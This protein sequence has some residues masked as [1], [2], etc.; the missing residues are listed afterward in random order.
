MRFFLLSLFTLSASARFLYD[1]VDLKG[2]DAYDFVI[3]GG[4]PGGSTVAD[5][6]SED[7][8]V[9]VLLLEA[10]GENDPTVDPALAIPLFCTTLTPNTAYD[11]NYTTIPQEELNGRSIPYPL[12]IGLGGS[13][14]VNCLVY[15]RGSADDI[16]TWA[17]LSGDEGWSWDNMLPYFKKGEKLNTVPRDGHNTTGQYLPAFHGF[18][19]VIGVSLPGYPYPFDGRVINTTQELAEFPYRVDMNSGE[20][21]GIGWV[22]TLV[23]AGQRSSAKTHLLRAEKEGRENIDVLLHARVSR[24]VPTVNGTLDL[25]SVEVLDSADE[26][27]K[28]LT[29]KSELILSAGS[30]MT[31]TILLHSGIGDPEL[32][33]PLGIDTIL[34]LPSVGKNLTDHI[35]VSTTFIVNST[36]TYDTVLRNETLLNEWIEEWAE[37][38][39]GLLTD[40][41]ENHAAWLRL[42]DN[43][44]VFEDYSDPSSGPL[45]AHYEFIF[46]N[47]LSSVRESGN[48]INVPT[49]CV[50]PASR[51]S[52]SI[53]SSDPFSRPLVDPA[54]LTA[55]VDILIVRESI[56]A[57]R[58]FFSGPA[59]EG[60]ILGS[61]NNNATTDEDIEE[62]I[63]E[64]AVS[65]FHPVSTASMSPEGADWGVVDPDLR[66]KGVTG[67]RVVDASVIPRLPAA[68]TSAAVYAVAERAADIIKAAYGLSVEAP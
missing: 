35:G 24:V 23:D 51:G 63:R 39:T 26:S 56:K 53:N 19:G 11:W 42:P 14:A 43:S 46:Q 6:L 50:S 3:V 33:E 29:A 62:F 55:P 4:G 48:Y 20:H 32:L 37:N 27:L 22:Q 8:T 25:R 13:S 18:D 67:L 38:K 65:F 9:S 58:R 47:G 15:T 59:W 1:F 21:I 36:D 30:V 17:K 68:H 44:T 45:T 12:G 40:T 10:G 41:S 52:V 34:S 16:D 64:N 31:P 28:V 57:A 5:R 61:L 49:A 2:L 60:Y 7:P 66:V 54:L